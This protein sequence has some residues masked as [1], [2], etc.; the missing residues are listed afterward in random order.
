MKIGILPNKLQYIINNNK[1]KFSVNILLLVKIGSIH[2]IKGKYGLAHYFEH[3][4][5]KGTKKFPKSKL[6]TDEIYKYGGKTNAFTSYDCTGYYITINSKYTEKAISI[7]ADIFFNSIFIDYQKE[8]NVVISE[9]KTRNTNPQFLCLSKFENMIYKNTPYNHNVIG[10]NSNIKKFTKKDIKDFYNKY[11]IPSNCVLSITGRTNKNVEKLIKKYFNINSIN[12]KKI[13]NITYKPVINFIDLQKKERNKII[14]QKLSQAHVYLGFPCYNDQNIFKKYVLYVISLI[15]GGNMSSKLF[16]KLR[17]KHGLVYT[18]SSTLDLSFDVGVFL[19]YFGTFNSKV[20]KVTKL[21][22]EELEKIKK[23]GFTKEELNKGINYILL[24]SEMNSE[25]N[26]SV[27][28]DY[29]YQLMYFNKINT[30]KHDEI[31]YKKITNKD[32]IEVANEIFNINK[33]NKCI[34][35]NVN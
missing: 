1:S 22:L 26:I 12:G 9:N 27:N 10:I 3:M 8:K 25:N 21:I 24:A 6:I 35:G 17:E 32:I 33:L 4:L 13:N 31:M 23:N 5:F 29:A 19:I 14:K 7:L 18:I 11:Y 30:L 2:E 15:L 34:I 16:I 20:N 28:I